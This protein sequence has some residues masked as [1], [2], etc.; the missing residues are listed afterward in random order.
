MEIFNHPKLAWDIPMAMG[1]PHG[2]PH[3]FKVVPPKL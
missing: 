2:N 1:L 3:I